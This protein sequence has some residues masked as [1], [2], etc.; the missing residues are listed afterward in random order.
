MAA[1]AT[2]HLPV[3]QTVLPRQRVHPPVRQTGLLRRHALPMDHQHQHASQMDHLPQRVNQMD[4]QRQHANLHQI[5]QMDLIQQQVVPGIAGVAAMVEE[6]E[7]EGA[8]VAE[9]GN[10][11]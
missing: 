1:M 4:H 6:E 2:G 7:V 3:R 10:F 5:F 8:A 11:I 9:D